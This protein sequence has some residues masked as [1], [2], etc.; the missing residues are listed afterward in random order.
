MDDVTTIAAQAATEELCADFAKLA[1][2]AGVIPDWCDANHP[3]G[4]AYQVA[5]YVL[6]IAFP[7]GHG[8]SLVPA[9]YRVREA[10]DG[11]LAK[12]DERRRLNYPDAPTDAFLIHALW[13]DR[14]SVRKIAKE[15]GRHLT[16]TQERIEGALGALTTTLGY[17]ARQFDPRHFAIPTEKTLPMGRSAVSEKRPKPQPRAASAKT[18][19]PSSRSE[20]DAMVAAYVAG[21]GQIRKAPKGRTR[22]YVDAKGVFHSGKADPWHAAGASSSIWQE[23]ESSEAARKGRKRP[24]KRQRAEAIGVPAKKLPGKEIKDDARIGNAKSHSDEVW[25][26]LFGFGGLDEGRDKEEKET[27]ELVEKFLDPET[28]ERRSELEPQFNEQSS[29]GKRRRAALTM[30]FLKSKHGEIRRLRIIER[31][32]EHAAWVKEIT[33]QRRP[34]KPEPGRKGLKDLERRAN[35]LLKEARPLKKEA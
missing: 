4:K 29:R 7:R 8:A 6:D 24:G 21:G 30:E 20:V 28:R 5:A 23:T 15:V 25:R 14:R 18:A 2:L 31:G 11:V 17:A 26:F 16:T 19:L 12:R 32:C 10:V 34:P 35:Q 27:H 33:Q 9:A 3:I 22:D 1:E 13:I